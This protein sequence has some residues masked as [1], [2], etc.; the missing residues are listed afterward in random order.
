[1]KELLTKIK[2][3]RDDI[4]PNASAK[5]FL[6]KSDVNLFLNGN[7]AKGAD[8]LKSLKE[9][10]TDK[11]K[12]YSA[13]LEPMLKELTTASKTS[14]I[15]DNEAGNI[16]Y[17]E[18]GKIVPHPVA[19][20]FYPKEPE[21]IE[22]MLQ[23]INEN[24]PGAVQNFPPLLLCTDPTSDVPRMWGG[25]QRLEVYK[26]AGIKDKVAVQIR[27]FDSD[28]AIRE[29][30][31]LEDLTRRQDNPVAVIKSFEY[32][33]KKESVAAKAR[34]GIKQEETLDR[35]R[36]NAGKATKVLARK[37]GKSEY[38]VRTVKAI[39][40]DD[41]LKEAG[42]SGKMD[43]KELF[44]KVNCRPKSPPSV[45]EDDSE[46]IHSVE[47]GIKNIP[48]SELGGESGKTLAKE[49][50]DDDASRIESTVQHQ[51]HQSESNSEPKSVNE[52]DGKEV[53]CPELKDVSIKTFFA[54]IPSDA[55]QIIDDNLSINLSM[56]PDNIHNF[57]NLIKER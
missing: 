8:V 2:D 29:G 39:L 6:L 5:S 15:K 28:D 43:L 27:H 7:G 51:D 24:G 40:I 18:L 38:F 14:S 37:V 16:E 56:C 25:F 21:Q 20:G 1:M 52:T 53:E 41:K 35:K 33:L 42:L 3:D 31:I 47:E 4:F 17:M 54:Q 36:S 48:P 10:G 11:A 45:K 44:Q 32:L 55:I 13:L 34:Q 50:I 23:Y 9:A 49:Q 19:E 46:I 22:G 12:E 30:M 57:L 26:K